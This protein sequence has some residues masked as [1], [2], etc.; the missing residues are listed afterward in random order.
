MGKLL[1]WMVFNY[2]K[3]IAISTAILTTV[4]LPVWFWAFSLVLDLRQSQ[5]NDRMQT[6]MITSHTKEISE[7]KGEIRAELTGIKSFLKMISEREYQE[8]KEARKNGWA[9]KP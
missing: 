3:T 4:I 6:E 9:Q 1:S 8:L 5:A 2:K 7:M